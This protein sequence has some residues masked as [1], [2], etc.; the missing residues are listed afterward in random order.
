[1]TAA[2]ATPAEISNRLRA[3]AEEEEDGE[4]E[5]DEERGREE[6]IRVLQ[7]YGW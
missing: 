7:S 6:D 3:E 4:E 2:T 1:M 5:E